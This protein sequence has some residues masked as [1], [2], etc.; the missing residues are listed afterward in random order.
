[1]TPSLSTN[2]LL[3]AK[4]QRWDEHCQPYEQGERRNKAVHP[5]VGNVMNVFKSERWYVG[6]EKAALNRMVKVS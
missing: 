6:S 1:M 3:K 4:P 5:L 2:P